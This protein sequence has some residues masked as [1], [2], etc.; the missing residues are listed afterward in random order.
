MQLSR[1]AL[2]QEVS[3]LSARNA[4]LEE[5]LGSDS[6]S[7]EAIA[8]LEKEN[9]VL[10]NLLGEKEEELENVLDDLKDVKN[11][12]KLQLEALYDQVAPQQE[13]VKVVES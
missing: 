10:L 5:S 1:S 13:E 9:T 12:Y 3:Y 4:E 11:L 6:N 2:L 7:A 8:R